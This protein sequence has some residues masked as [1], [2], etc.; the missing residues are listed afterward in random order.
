MIS[1]LFIAYLLVTLVGAGTMAALTFYGWSRRA[2]PGA[3][4]FAWLMAD[5]TLT[6]LCYILMAISQT[7][8][9]L[10]FWARLRYL[11]LAT[12]PVLFL[13]FV[14]EDQEKTRWLRYAPTLLLVPAITQVLIWTNELHGAFFVEWSARRTEIGLEEIVLYGDGARLHA[15]YGFL[16]ITT[17]LALLLGRVIS[18]RGVYR[19]QAVLL[20]VGAILAVL[21]NVVHTMGLVRSS[22][23]NLTPFGL[24]CAAVFFTVALFR[25]K[26]LDLVPV[27]FDTVYK[28]IKDPV[29]VFSDQKRLVAV[30]P[31]AEKLM[32][33]TETELLG[34]HAHEVFYRYPDLVEQ[35][36]DVPEVHTE[37]ILSMRKGDRT[38]ELLIS[39]L[40]QHHNQIAGR[41][42]VLRDITERKLA[43]KRDLELSIERERTRLLASFI[44]YSSHDL[45]TPLSKMSMALHIARR[46]EDEQKR[47]E[48][49]DAIEQE[50]LKMTNIIEEMHLLTRLENGLPIALTTVS[51]HQVVRL[52]P[53]DIQKIIIEKRLSLRLPT[54]SD[55]LV[56]GDMQLL[57]QAF[58]NL[59][60]NAAIYT[61]E[62]GSITVSIYSENSRGII[63]VADTGMGI[64]GEQLEMIF[65]HFAKVNTARTA[66]GSGAGLGLAIVKKI[67]EVHHGEVTVVSRPGLGSTFRLM[68][69][70]AE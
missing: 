37:I 57:Q 33:A 3:Q 27:A 25:Y 66:D 62:D 46:T 4:T 34:K 5:F 35:Y 44:Q 49:L 40:Y 31:A 18:S 41:L 22:T 10:Y 68:L 24:V 52:T 54:E 26:L 53:T 16:I 47:L 17:G 63:E 42:V 36:L 61:P 55:V 45:R 64:E 50:I 20:L 21:F 2:I 65:E 69:P 29:F 6:S 51:L 43:S 70:L 8:E 56:C 14:L 30:N 39:P 19:K 1:P 12:I 59:L 11:G 9:A 13:L 60:H 58:R 23:P 7:E 67:M 38:Y 28:S 15:A 48:K 32:M